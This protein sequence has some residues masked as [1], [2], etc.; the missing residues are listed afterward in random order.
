MLAWILYDT[1]FGNG[2]ILA[3]FLK[4]EFPDNV[5]VRTGDV[6]KISPD[7]VAKDK[8]EVLIVGGAIRM[9]RGGTKSKKW[10]KKLNK[11]LEK[12]DH[13]VN[14]ATGFFTHGLPTDKIQGYA[15]RFLKKF[16]KSSMIEKTYDKLLTARVKEQEGPIIDEEMEKS[17][18]FIHN[19]LNW[20]KA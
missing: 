8:P 16:E 3:E 14:Y 5:E 9:F 19:F 15:K 6:K 2:K 1:Q 20:I 12:I 13:K 4:K 11:N 18:N 17:K 7:S 10:L